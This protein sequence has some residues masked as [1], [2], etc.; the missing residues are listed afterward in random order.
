MW[1]KV[2]E[3]PASLQR[4]LSNQGYA[5]PDVEV[6]S[7]ETYTLDPGTAFEGSRG[8][9]AAVNLATGQS[10]S[11]KGSWGGANAFERSIDHDQTD[12]PIVPN[13]AVIKGE[14]GGRGTFARVIVAPSTLAALL[15]AP[16]A[17][18]TDAQAVI[19][20]VFKQCKSFARMDEARRYGIKNAQYAEAVK[21]CV[22]KGLIKQASNG[23]T[24]I[25]TEGKNAV[26]GIVSGRL[27]AIESAYRAKLFPGEA[28]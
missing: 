9:C 12:R 14:S 19:L 16:S 27:R 10:E 3:L 2:K 24:Q 7:A 22:A 23:A 18:L 13:M 8:F 1:V 17:E 4:A 6:K 20:A 26:S 15:P 11:V 28:S 21:E 25:T 5:R